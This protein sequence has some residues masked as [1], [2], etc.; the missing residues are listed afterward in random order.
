MFETKLQYDKAFA[1]LVTDEQRKAFIEQYGDGSDLPTEA[2]LA[3]TRVETPEEAA[4]EFTP[5]TEDSPVPDFIPVNAEPASEYDIEQ[6]AK[7]R[8]EERVSALMG[9]IER[10]VQARKEEY[11]VRDENGDILYDIETGEP[12][13]RELSTGEL[14]LNS[15]EN[16]I[17]DTKSGFAD[18]GVGVNEVVQRLIGDEALEEWAEDYDSDFIRA[19]TDEGTEELI[20]QA[21]LAE[22]ERTHRT[23]TYGEGR[24]QN[25]AAAFVN[26][27][28]SIG[29]SAA[30]STLT[31]GGGLPMQFMGQFY[32]DYNDEV[33][34]EKGKSLAQLREDGEDSFW[35]P[36]AFGTI[37]G[38]SERVG[39][40]GAGK[41]ITKK[42]RGPFA[43]KVAHRL[44]SGNKEGLTE[45]F[46]TGLEE[47]NLAHAR[48]EDATE[49]FVNGITSKDAMEAYLQGFTGGATL[50]GKGQDHKDNIRKINRAIQT[51]RAPVDERRINQLAA[52]GVQL[53]QALSKTT[54]ELAREKIQDQIKE[55]EREMKNVV[56]NANGIAR[57][58]TPPQIDQA[59]NIWE[60]ADKLEKQA[61]QLF[62]D[63]KAGNITK[64]SYIE[65]RKGIQLDLDKARDQA[66]KLKATVEGQPN[67]VE[68]D[69]VTPSASGVWNTQAKH[70]VNKLAEDKS[71]IND[72][73]Q[74]ES[75]NKFVR[76]K[77]KSVWDKVNPEL[78]RGLTLD[79]IVNSV[80]WVGPQ[81]QQSQSVRGLLESYKPGSK[82]T[83][84]TYLLGALDNKILGVVQDFT[85]E[86]AGRG[87]EG[88]I[89]AP[90]DEGHGIQALDEATEVENVLEQEAAK[91]DVSA[92]VIA[93]RV[94]LK[95]NVAED[96][97]QEAEKFIAINKKFEGDKSLEQNVNDF[98][99]PRLQKPIQDSMGKKQAY[100]D[101]LNKNA[102]E[103][104][105]TIPDKALR[106]GF[107]GNYRQGGRPTV[108]EFIDYH[109][110][111]NTTKKK[112]ALA[113][114]LAKT[115]GARAAVDF[116]NNEAKSK[117]RIIEGLD[118]MINGLNKLLGDRGALQANIAAIPLHVLI[119]GLRTF[120]AT[121]E[122]TRDMLQASKAAWNE[123]RDHHQVRNAFAGISGGFTG[124]QQWLFGE[125]NKQ[126]G[127]SM[128]EKI[129]KLVNQFEAKQEETTEEA[130]KE[131][132]TAPTPDNEFKIR[133][134]EDARSLVENGMEFED[135]LAKAYEDN[136][137]GKDIID[138]FDWYSEV[139]DE[140]EKLSNS[141]KSQI[142]Q[143]EAS[144]QVASAKEVQKAINPEYT[145]DTFQAST[146][147]ADDDFASQSREYKELLKSYGLGGPITSRNDREAGKKWVAD[148]LSK[149]MPPQFFRSTNLAGSSNPQRG[150]FFSNSKELKDNVTGT[151]P[152]G[153]V[154]WDIVGK[155][156]FKDHTLE[157]VMK[158]SEKHYDKQVENMKA[159]RHFAM[160][161]EKM[162]QDNPENARYIVGV[163]MGLSN[164]QAGIIRA[165][166][167]MRGSSTEFKNTSGGAKYAGNAAKVHVEEHTM[168]QNLVARYI[169]HSALDPNVKM[170]EAFDNVEKNFFQI[171]LSIDD[172]N[173]MKGT[174]PNTGQKFN[175]TAKMP[176]GWKMSDSPWARY[177]NSNVNSINGGIDPN[178]IYLFEEGKTLAE[179]YAKQPEPK[180]VK[181]KNIKLKE[182]FVAPG[183]K[184]PPTSWP[185]DRQI[186]SL[187]GSLKEFPLHKKRINAYI[188][189][190]RSNQN[191]GLRA[192][193]VGRPRKFRRMK[194]ITPPSLQGK[195]AGAEFKFAQQAAVT[196]QVSDR[197][198]NLIDDTINNLEKLTGPK[199][200]LQ[201]NIAAVP[202]HIVVGG[203]RATKLAYRGSRD[204]VKAIEA[205]Y[206]KVKDYMSR[207]EWADFTSKAVRE[208]KN[209]QSPAQKNLAVASKKAVAIEKERQQTVA[210]AKKAGIEISDDATITEAS[211]A[212][213]DKAKKDAEKAKKVEGTKEEFDK[214]FESK[215]ITKLGKIAN[216]FLIGSSAEDFQGLMYRLF[217]G[218]KLD[219]M[220]KNLMNPYIEG[221]EAYKSFKLANNKIFSQAAK[222]F[223]RKNVLNTTIE[224]LKSDQAPE[225]VKVF[226]NEL[227]KIDD[228][229]FFDGLQGDDDVATQLSDYLRKVKRKEFIKTFL[230]NSNAIF[231]DDDG[232]IRSNI[233]DRLGT[234]YASALSNM[235][236]RMESGVNRKQYTTGNKEAQTML[237]LLNQSNAIVMQWNMRSG[238][239][240]IISALNYMRATGPGFFRLDKNWNYI[241]EI[242]K[243]DY[244]RERWGSNSFDLDA[245]EIA[246]SKKHNKIKRFYNT[247]IKAGF[248]PTKAVDALAIAVGGAGYYRKLLE[249]YNGDKQLAMRDFVKFTEENQ[250]SSDP[251]K[252]SQL[253]AGTLGRLVF[254]FLNTPFQYARLSKRAIQDLRSGR[255]SRAGN[256]GKLGYY[257]VVQSALFEGLR[258][259]ISPLEFF[260]FFDDEEDEEDWKVGLAIDGWINTN[261]KTLGWY[262]TM[263]AW[264]NDVLKEYLRQK[265]EGKP[266]PAK[267]AI[268]ATKISPPISRKLNDLEGISK[269]LY[270]QN[271]GENWQ[272][273]K[274]LALAG[275]A[276]NLPTYRVYQ[277]AENLLA[278]ADEDRTALDKL[279]K[280][281]GW[282]DF[283]LS[284][285]KDREGDVFEP[286]K[287]NLFES[288]DEDLFS[289]EDES[290]FNRLARGEVGQAH[291]DGTIEVDPNL[292]PEEKAKTIA[293][294]KQ[295]VKDMKTHGLDYDDHYIYWD[296]KRYARKN[297]K[298]RYK[299]SWHMEGA[300]ELPWEKRAEAAESP[301]KNTKPKPGS[302]EWEEARRRGVQFTQDWYNE[303]GTR[304]MLEEQAPRYVGKI[305]KRLEDIG[306]THFE[307]GGH[308]EEGEVAEYWRNRYADKDAGEH[309]HN[310][311]IGPGH[312]IT[313][314]GLVPHE[315]THAAGWDY[316]LGKKVLEVTGG[317]DKSTRY[318]RYLSS[319]DEAYGNLQELRQ[320]LELK[321]TQR[322]LTPAQLQK[323]IDE[324]G[325]DDV[326]AYIKAFGIENVTKAHNQVADIG[327][328]KRSL[329]DLY[330]NDNSNIA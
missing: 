311:T 64:E 169:L 132:A 270:R 213:A 282:S 324:K 18:L 233:V 52:K 315:L 248:T 138:E 229:K 310:V 107:M 259:M 307:H 102:K 275:D 330:N 5:V 42:I 186:A 157:S 130:T 135:A 225:N 242:L 214:I 68:K 74:S 143:E 219:W 296:N 50:A 16:M 304:A 115:I 268:S 309:E 285:K 199:G 61:Q 171:M 139:E 69:M 57:K 44:L 207:Q 131:E 197:F 91:T 125:I 151:G 261:L 183:L 262:G 75:L 99:V 32:R 239:L 56:P 189:D 77:A 244:A 104:L 141:L 252:I 184:A 165:A 3:V 191:V 128:N 249:Q 301:L 201:A 59:N 274:A 258:S 62:E 152:T 280:A 112:R 260:N 223:G 24:D 235:L 314:P 121:Y 326:K 35:V 144:E 9:E 293:H 101:Y 78:K 228:G 230:D 147:V 256:L 92:P 283:A 28:T 167:P 159:L 273:V 179:I 15:V 178:S 126:E 323:I 192:N 158:Q 108:Q 237:N 109:Q 87:F 98:F 4:G 7:Y 82:A 54:N 23:G 117:D 232:K 247:L 83:P 55:V 100:V 222:V 253:Q 316:D 325:N 161:I 243:S 173:K 187:K 71:N 116:V 47:A 319:P 53:R 288:G 308:L 289:D 317:P 146:E 31:L 241:G 6:Y 306:E 236:D 70:E 111:G 89:E 318:G 17:A 46:Q 202:L 170:S 272:Q 255:G 80:M 234:D 227:R 269:S 84:S 181:K 10:N 67:Q 166:A 60:K 320:I 86:K 41:F 216:K 51:M 209:E 105:R 34:A 245:N 133:A 302:P 231:K 148:V 174:N 2:E 175:Y 218:Q 127:K 164:S 294:E 182:G 162:V 329:E 238:V 290:P 136:L 303:P 150:F 250:Q 299:G 278:L 305:D 154:N 279:L 284:H 129:D 14:M 168:P 142:K 265:E 263:A 22:S 103:I 76:S 124:F 96:I 155:V 45:V 58:M 120:K 217:P 36:A 65:A 212:I 90:T 79:D 1:D 221:V 73:L 328:P 286:R 33:A 177:F 205:G 8:E 215:R 19:F 300:S 63:Y 264:G 196:E 27:L 119:G 322:D 313:R 81:G 160:Q 20:R 106:E 149:Y 66:G 13:E 291:R 39:L 95:P 172:D 12:I 220:E 188:K 163:F 38:I 292:S 40:K 137:K 114:Q 110:E 176:G 145:L 200:A 88:K 118:Q 140:V 251:S 123:L 298:I 185:I 49:A 211:K 271:R 153:N 180:T 208:V 312:S 203:L 30:V 281:F 193:P 246:T 94:G 72:I 93:G 254:A 277:K 156:N 295:H 48:G 267:L 206:Q 122:A 113:A 266:D 327:S 190:L 11:A 204:L 224:D 240:Q 226:A 21:E 29:S 287:D 25:I 297:G 210:K 37:A 321:P 198:E 276:L 26:S 97:R 43:Q 257:T 134:L 195:R 85:G 194:R